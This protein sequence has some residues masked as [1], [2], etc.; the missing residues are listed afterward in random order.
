MLSSEQLASTKTRRMVRLRPALK[1]DLAGIVELE[2]AVVAAGEGVVKTLDDLQEQTA[3][4]RLSQRMNAESGIWIVAEW[5]DDSARIVGCCRLDQ[6]RAALIRHVATLS[7]EV[8]P[9][10]QGVGIGRL[11]VNRVLDWARAGRIRR[12][13][14]YVRADNERA[15]KLYESTGFG[16]EGVRKDFVLL[17]DGRYVDDLLMALLI[18]PSA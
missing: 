3:I 15:R 7:I 8:D 2:R 10:A 16:V 9:S 14:L 11:L 18:Q 17:P 5:A 12:V 13:E 6:H 1:S 4:E